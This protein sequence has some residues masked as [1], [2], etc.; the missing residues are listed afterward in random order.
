MADILFLATFE[1]GAPALS[2][3]VQIFPTLAIPAPVVFDD[4]FIGRNP[5]IFV[6]SPGLIK[7]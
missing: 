2:R 6:Q 7:N 3:P 4:I 5:E 1:I